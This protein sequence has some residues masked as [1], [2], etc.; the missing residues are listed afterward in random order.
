M[1][2][3]HHFSNTFTAILH[4]S[5]ESEA[6]AHLEEE[7]DGVQE[8]TKALRRMAQ[9]CPPVVPALSL[10]S[11][12]TSMEVQ[13]PIEDDPTSLPLL[14]KRARA[15]LHFRAMQNRI[16][17]SLLRVVQKQLQSQGHSGPASTKKDPLLH[18]GLLELCDVDMQSRALE[19]LGV[20]ISYVLPFPYSF[21]N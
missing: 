12:D 11:D 10:G 5:S 15:T 21:I 13:S 1:T 19:R 3:L 18:A 14:I 9:L 16:W 4:S 6:L 8:F 2:F 17:I 7:G 20:T